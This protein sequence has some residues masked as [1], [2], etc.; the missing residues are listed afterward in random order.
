MSSIDVSDLRAGDTTASWRRTQKFIAG[1]EQRIDAM[2]ARPG[3][4][5]GAVEV[6]DGLAAKT[7]ATD[8]ATKAD[9]TRA[10]TLSGTSATSAA[11]NGASTT[12]VS[13]SLNGSISTSTKP[14]ASYT[15]GDR[16][17]T[18]LLVEPDHESLA[19]HQGTQRR[20]GTLAAD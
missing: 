15:S 1:L 5:E 19:T 11:A 20:C 12:Q 13:S 14:L 8:S 9:A 3:S 16:L 10:T 6:T 2:R 18:A 7:N 4:A 17:A